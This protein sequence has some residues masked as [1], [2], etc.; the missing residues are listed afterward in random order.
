MSWK[1]VAVSAVI[2]SGVVACLAL[3]IS[4]QKTA[5]ANDIFFGE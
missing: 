5:D 4:Y 2:V 1:D 3:L